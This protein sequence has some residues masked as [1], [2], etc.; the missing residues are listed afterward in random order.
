MRLCYCC[1]GAV[2]QRTKRKGHRRYDGQWVHD[3][4]AVSY[5]KAFE[6]LNANLAG[7]FRRLG[8]AAGKFIA[9]ETKA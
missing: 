9:K 2:D 8:K 5:A 1:K 7:S 3:D 4:C 6:R